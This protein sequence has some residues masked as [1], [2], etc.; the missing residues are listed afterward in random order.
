MLSRLDVNALHTENTSVVDFQEL[1]LA[2]VNDP[3]YIGLLYSLK[4]SQ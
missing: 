4:E 3:T 1:A 2:Q